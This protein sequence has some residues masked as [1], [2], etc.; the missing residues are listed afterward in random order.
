[1]TLIGVDEDTALV[2][3]ADGPPSTAP[4]PW[5]VMGRQGVSVF[6]ADGEVHRAAGATVMLGLDGPESEH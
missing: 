1:M 4:S 5:Q 3:V 6:T 2:Q